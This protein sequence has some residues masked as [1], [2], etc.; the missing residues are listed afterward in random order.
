MIGLYCHLNCIFLLLSALLNVLSDIMVSLSS[1]VFSPSATHPLAFYSQT[2]DSCM[3][4]CQERKFVLLSLYVCVSMNL[5]SLCKCCMCER[6]REC[7]ICVAYLCT[8]GS[9]FCCLRV[10]MRMDSN[11]DL[12]VFSPS[13]LHGS[14]IY[15]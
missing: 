1:I 15:I 13:Q 8:D 9:V 11:I 12:C 7:S 4:V 5:T 2:M 6:S 10:C 14:S 3:C